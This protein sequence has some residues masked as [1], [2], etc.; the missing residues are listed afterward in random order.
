LLTVLNYFNYGVVLAF[1]FTYKNYIAISTTVSTIDAR[2]LKDPKTV[3]YYVY[4][5]GMIVVY[6]VIAFTIAFV[7]N[8]DDRTE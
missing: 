1:L 2:Y 3:Q 4:N 8:R 5:L 7:Y 6:C